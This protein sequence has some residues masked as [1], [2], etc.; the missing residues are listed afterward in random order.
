MQTYDSFRAWGVVHVFVK[1]KSYVAIYV[2]LII[3]RKRVC[4]FSKQSDILNMSKFQ[5][6]LTS[7]LWLYLQVQIVC[8]TTEN[9]FN[10]IILIRICNI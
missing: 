1:W 9:A 10:I 5:C 8:G 3:T 7:L 6:M 4:E 2:S